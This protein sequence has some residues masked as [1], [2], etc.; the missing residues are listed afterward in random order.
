VLCVARPVP[1]TSASACVCRSG[2][3][4]LVKPSEIAARTS[5]VTAAL[6]RRYMAPGGVQVLEGG[7]DVSTALLTL[8]FNHIFYTGSPQ[9]VAVSPTP[10]LDR[11]C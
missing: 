2:N 10:P 9:M 6:L 5:A 4:V 11:C 7:V 3:T 1:R 8:P